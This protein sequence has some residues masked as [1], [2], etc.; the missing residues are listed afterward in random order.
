MATGDVY[1]I[2]P[3]RWL[4]V[5]SDAEGFEIGVRRAAAR[6]AQTQQFGQIDRVAVGNMI[7][8]SGAPASGVN[9][10]AARVD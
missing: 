10:G 7:P 2:T 1:E 4:K 6:I 5:T 8:I 3:A 9:E